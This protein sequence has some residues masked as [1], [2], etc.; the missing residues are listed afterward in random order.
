MKKSLKKILLCLAVAVVST[1]VMAETK[2]FN[3]SLTPDVAVYPR[4]DTIE[5]FTA[6][7]WGENQQTSLALG[8]ANGTIG[9]SAGLNWGFILNYADKYKG[10]Q[11][12]AINYTKESF[13]GWQSGLIDYTKGTMMGLQAGAVNYAGCVTGLELGLVNY[14]EDVDS[15]LQIGIV[16]IVRNNKVWFSDFP[17]SLAPVMIFANW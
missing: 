11:W 10:I 2:P 3:F 16:N 15:G 9:D 17:N 6:S 8:I 7:V 4:T 1:A 12:A 5:G 14:T 13:L